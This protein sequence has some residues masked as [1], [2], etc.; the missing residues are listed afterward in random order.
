VSALS[1]HVESTDSMTNILSV[2]HSATN[3]QSI[4][5][6]KPVLSY[7]ISS[8]TAV[9]RLVVGFKE[10]LHTWNSISWQE[11]AGTTSWGQTDL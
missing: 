8:P 11:V 2:H 1:L 10:K 5:Q 9:I 7:K 4:M 6:S 3:M